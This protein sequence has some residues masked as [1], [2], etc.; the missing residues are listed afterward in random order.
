MAGYEIGVW[1]G[2]HLP[3][4]SSC[5]RYLIFLASNSLSP[6]STRMRRNCLAL[7]NRRKILISPPPLTSSTLR[8][9]HKSSLHC[10][11]LRSSQISPITC[12]FGEPVPVK[13]RDGFN[14]NSQSK[15]VHFESVLRKLDGSTHSLSLL[16]TD[17]TKELR[18][19]R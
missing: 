10:Q 1:S 8:G 2:D 9:S 12:C 16:V 18:S 6:A 3:P 13:R 4:S 15:I 5:R 11:K 7:V 17:V 19:G 14:L